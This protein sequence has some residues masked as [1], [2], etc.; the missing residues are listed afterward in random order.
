MPSPAAEND[1][2]G[3]VF[4]HVTIRAADREA[5]R[6]FYETVLATLGSAKTAGGEWYTEWDDFSIAAATAERPPTK[7]LQVGFVAPSRGDVD[8][9]H[10]AAT[11]HGYRDNGEPR[12]RT[13]YHPGYYAAFV[14]DPSGHN[15]E[16]VNHNR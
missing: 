14:L 11:S 16:V 13:S 15:I 8:A 7:G 3:P 5:S 10:R 9:F 2:V 4:D 1:I 12:E 6:R